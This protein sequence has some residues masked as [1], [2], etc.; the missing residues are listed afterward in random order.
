MSL[1]AA[2]TTESCHDY[3]YSHERANSP[4][5]LSGRDSVAVA[6]KSELGTLHRALVMGDGNPGADLDI[7]LQFEAPA[8]VGTSSSLWIDSVDDG[9]RQEPFTVAL[10][11]DGVTL[12]VP[13]AAMSSARKVIF[14]GNDYQLL[15]L[16]AGPTVDPLLHHRTLSEDGT[17]GPVHD[18]I[19]QRITDVYVAS[20]SIGSL[21]VFAHVLP[22]ASTREFVIHVDAATG[23]VQQVWEAP[24]DRAA[25]SYIAAFWFG[26]ALQLLAYDADTHGMEM[27]D[28][29]MGASTV[30]SF[31]VEI[32]GVRVLAPSDRGEILFVA[33]ADAVFEL[34]AALNITWRHAL[35]A[36]YPINGALGMDWLRLEYHPLDSETLEP[37]S[38]SLVRGQ[39][40]ADADVWRTVIASD[41]PT[42][43]GH[44]CMQLGTGY[45][46][47]QPDDTEPLDPPTRRSGPIPADIR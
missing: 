13:I 1:W 36:E 43:T 4:T 47:R 5:V 37:G 19:S 22:H 7:P 41:S 25:T 42:M 46:T 34:D 27:I 32:A 39:G 11:H 44:V 17:L 2:C 9:L 15:W 35:A 33:T 28:T 40:H 10:S 16:G 12:V 18:L 24:A 26:A 21:F 8:A 6:W 3:L 20:D 38:Y 31:P 23:A 29:T 14:D 30:P 45:A